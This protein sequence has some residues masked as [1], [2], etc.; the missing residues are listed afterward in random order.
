VQAAVV[1]KP[2]H[3]EETVAPASWPAV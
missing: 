1:W 2:R 3:I